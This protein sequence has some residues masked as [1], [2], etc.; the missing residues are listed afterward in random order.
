MYKIVKRFF[1]REIYSANDVSKFVLSGSI[2][3]EEYKEITG[4]DYAA[5]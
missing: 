1:D 3:E 4:T 2:T 5:Q